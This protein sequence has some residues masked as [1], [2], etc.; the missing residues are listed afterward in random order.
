MNLAGGTWDAG[1]NANSVI[2]WLHPYIRNLV[3]AGDY[4]WINTYVDGT[5]DYH[6]LIVVGWAK[7]ETCANALARINNND[8]ITYEN[9]NLYRSYDEAYNDP[10]NVPRTTSQGIAKVVPWVADF[11]RLQ[12][13]A[14]RPFYCTRYQNDQLVPN[15][16]FQPHDWW[17]FHMP[18]LVHYTMNEV[19]INPN[20]TWTSTSGS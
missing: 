5:G 3:K 20:W 9:G 13:S 11:N 8:W 17:F 19:Y 14:P 6:G 10:N 18:E 1:Y 4:A 2:H 16:Y 7:I 12:R 15:G